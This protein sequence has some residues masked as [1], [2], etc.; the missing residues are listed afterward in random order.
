MNDETELLRHM[1]EIPSITGNEKEVAKFLK[2]EMEQRGFTSRIDE[3]GNVIGEIGEGD[4]II[5]LLGHIDTVPG[6]IKVEIKDNKLF[7]RGSVDAKGCM[8]AFI[9]AAERV[10][11]KL[12]NNDNNKRIMMVGCVEEEGSSKGAWQIVESLRDENINYCIIGEPSSVDGITIGYR[13]NIRFNYTVTQKNVHYATG[14][15]SAQMAIEFHNKLCEYVN[16][17]KEKNGF[18]DVNVEIRNFSTDFNGL[19]DKASVDYVIRMPADFDIDNFLKFLEKE[20]TNKNTRISNIGIEKPIKAE[21]NNPLVKT[22]LK[23]IRQNGLEPKFKLKT[24]TADMNIIGNE[25][26]MPIVAYGPG[27]SSLDHTPEEHIELEEYEKAIKILESV[28]SEL[29]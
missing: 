4:E 3:A 11:N 16:Y 10:K 19:E 24:G 18:N 26:K 21:K 6:Y 8:A 28:L 22:F 7:G 29:I 15:S 12:S 17:D 5:L 2:S 27:D 13:G 20:K 23:S 1:V 14:T 9:S 25:F